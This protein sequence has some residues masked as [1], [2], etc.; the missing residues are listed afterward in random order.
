MDADG[1]REACVF[2]C[3]RSDDSGSG[4]DHTLGDR[5]R[6]SAVCVVVF[7]KTPSGVRLEDASVADEEH[8][9]PLGVEERDRM[10]GDAG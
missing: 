6:E 3:A 5:A 1:L 9:T 7:A 8:E 4:L 2:P 10:V